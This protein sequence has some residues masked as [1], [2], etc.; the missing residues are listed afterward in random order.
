MKSS[1]QLTRLLKLVPYLQ[2]HQ[3]ISVGEVAQHFGVA[4]RQVV[5]DIEVLQFCGLPEGFHGD[6]FEVDIDEVRD[7]GHIFF[8][9]ADVLARPMRMRLEEA[10]S[11]LVA[12]E[13]VV[14]T[15]GGSEAALSAL[16]KLRDVLGGVDPAVSVA[17]AAGAPE[18]RQV[19]QAAIDARRVVE[20]TYLGSGRRSASRPEVEPMR[21]RVVDGFAYVDAW[22]PARSDWRSYRLDRIEALHIT[23]ATFTPREGLPENAT[24][25]FDDVAQRL[26]LELTPDADW[27]A[28]YY[29]V[30]HRH[31]GADHIWVTFPVASPQWAVSLLLRLGDSVTG[32]SDGNVA[33][34]A[35]GE[36]RAALA[37]YADPPD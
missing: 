20:M 12:L 14:E 37:H 34:A 35:A 18:H 9:N 36:A 7:A 22:T 30:T 16:A 33:Q 25:W 5:S 1:E 17:V 6:L 24:S 21:L 19:L 10:T 2:Q 3:G 27:V 28:E 13:V 29:P 8:R 26:E 15:S 31:A 32:V 11:L 4:P 23:D